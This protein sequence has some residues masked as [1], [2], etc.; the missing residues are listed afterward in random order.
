MS[1]FLLYFTTPPSPLS[2]ERKIIDISQP[3]WWNQLLL[4]PSGE[5]ASTRIAIENHPGVGEIEAYL[6]AW[7]FEQISRWEPRP[8]IL[9]RI[10]EVSVRQIMDLLEPSELLSLRAANVSLY[11]SVQ[12]AKYWRQRLHRELG[13]KT[14]YSPEQPRPLERY[15]E[16]RATHGTPEQRDPYLESAHRLLMDP[17]YLR[18]RMASITPD[19]LSHLMR[20]APFQRSGEWPKKPDVKSMLE[21]TELAAM[22]IGES[23][24]SGL[25]PLLGERW[26]LLET[27]YT[28]GRVKG[29]KLDRFDWK[30]DDHFAVLREIQQSSNPRLIEALLMS[31]VTPINASLLIMHWNPK[32]VLPFLESHPEMMSQLYDYVISCTRGL[33]TSLRKDSE[34]EI[35]QWLL[36]HYP[37]SREERISRSIWAPSKE[38]IDV[39]LPPRMSVEEQRRLGRLAI[40]ETRRVNEQSQ[41]EWKEGR[42]LSS[43]VYAKHLQD[44]EDA[45]A[46][47]EIVLW[48]DDATLD[49]D[50]LR[51]MMDRAVNT[52]DFVLTLIEEDRYNPSSIEDLLDPLIG[53]DRQRILALLQERMSEN[54][55]AALQTLMGEMGIEW[56]LK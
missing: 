2:G 56:R 50:V 29:G 10:P 38:I 11:R 19:E 53:S 6:R 18:D 45:G 44:L 13:A 4:L 46:F 33:L 30:G 35:L 37:L 47:F 48:S 41:I 32:L 7:G 26:S 49:H 8:S 39:L 51:W 42:S 9:D 5:R 43:Q 36:E 22:A 14:G 40:E 24:R 34:P 52:R 20:E 21:F 12:D 15:I 1:A 55:T 16:Y 28:I 27:Y 17:N 54:D 3:E 23:E 25:L 31:D